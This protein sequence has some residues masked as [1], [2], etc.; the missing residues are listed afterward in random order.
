ML[1]EGN[2]VF[3]HPTPAYTIRQGEKEDIP[4]LSEQEHDRMIALCRIFNELPDQEIETAD[5]IYADD[6]DAEDKRPGAIFNRRCDPHKFATYLAGKGWK[7][8]KKMGEKY[9]FTRPGKETGVSATWNHDGRKLL[10]VFSSA[11]EFETHRGAN[12]KGH[13]PFSVFTK[14]SHNGE[15]KAA[16]AELVKNGFVDLDE[17]DEVE[18][19]TTI[20]AKPFNLDSILPASCRSMKDY[21]NQVADAY[22]VHPEMVLLPAMSAMSLALCGA[23]KLEVLENWIEDAPLWSIV[24]AEASERKSPVMKD[25]MKPIYTYFDNFNKTHGRQISSMARR[26]KALEAALQAN[27]TKYEKMVSNNKDASAVERDIEDIE[28]Q[29]ELLPPIVN[30]PNLVQNDI[31]PEALVRQVQDNG[32]VCGVISAEADPIEVALGLYSDKPNFTIY[33]KG[34]SVE[35]YTS[36]RVGNGEIIVDEPRIVLSV[37]MQREPMQKL[38]DSRQARKRGFIA[39]TLFAVPQS[40][41]GH[42][43]ID[44]ASVNPASQMWWELVIQRVMA[45]PHRLRLHDNG[46]S[47][48]LCQDDPVTLHLTESA[49]G[50]LWEARRI[51]ESELAAG[52]DHDDDTGWGGKLMGNICRIALVLHFVGGGSEEAAIDAE[53]MQAALNWV[54]PLTE[55]YYSAQGEVG[56]V[57]LDKLV[58]ATMIKMKDK[59]INDGIKVR[60]LYNSVRTRAMD[61]ATDWEPIWQRMTDLGFIRVVNGEKPKKGP[62]PKVVKLHP[63]F[64]GLAQ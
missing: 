50:L 4:V 43:E 48:K 9:W 44:T 31:T 59:G 22:Q 63:N 16:T 56:E 29:I 34:Y 26:R 19:L 18:P 13:T 36:N 64:H 62:V 33:L 49:K 38:A 23:V 5:Y 15:F 27:S 28:E 51:N 8:F 58:R 41:V 2:I 57:G 20:R 32:E 25:V 17:W 11:T 30:L 39:R 12:M 7:V 54:D 6:A 1:G 45:M 47:V 35:R 60:D 46:S 14:L 21:I 55:H 52:G 53:T 40:K 24:V 42:R 37:M 61:K 10:C 3:T